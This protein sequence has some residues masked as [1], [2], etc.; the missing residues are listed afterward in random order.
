MTPFGFSPVAPCLK[1]AA[2]NFFIGI[3]IPTYTTILTPHNTLFY[4]KSGCQNALFYTKSH[5]RMHYFTFQD[6]CGAGF[7]ERNRQS[8]RSIHL[9]SWR[10]LHGN[11]YTG[12]GSVVELVEFLF[13]T[14]F[15]HLGHRNLIVVDHG[16]GHEVEQQECGDAEP[17]DKERG[18]YCRMH[19]NHTKI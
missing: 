1:G 19:I 2:D 12:C 16:T 8:P 4:I 11:R 14:A 10:L 17:R 9:S 18:D 13:V 5:F 15:L 6:I 3:P 7:T